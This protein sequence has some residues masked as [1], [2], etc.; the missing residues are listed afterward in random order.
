M[1]TSW[2]IV[3]DITY[4]PTAH[5]QVDRQTDRQR[6]RQTYRQTDRHL[7][8]EGE[9]SIAFAARVKK[10]IAAAGGLVELEWDGQLKRMKVPDKIISQQFDPI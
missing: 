4:L 7:W 10:Q 3:V 2:A 5:I 1:M 6:G 8:Q 9:S